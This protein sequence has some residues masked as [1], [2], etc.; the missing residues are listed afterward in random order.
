MTLRE[1]YATFDHF[2]LNSEYANEIG[3]KFQSKVKTIYDA[4]KDGGTKA[5]FIT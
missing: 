2:G 3:N 4:K 5:G 1:L